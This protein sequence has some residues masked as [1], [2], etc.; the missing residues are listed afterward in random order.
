MNRFKVAKLQMNN[1]EY[2]YALKTIALGTSYLLNSNSYDRKKFWL[3][4]EKADFLFDFSGSESIIKAYEQCPPI[5]AIINYQVNCYI[6]GNTIVKNSKGEISTSDRAKRINK[7]K[8][9]PNPLQTEDEFDA[10]GQFYKRLFG[11]N[12]V[13]C[14]DNLPVG[15]DRTYAKQLW[16]IPPNLVDIR[17][18][19]KCFF[20]IDFENE[21]YIEVWLRHGN[22]STKLTKGSYHIFKGNAPNF[23]NFYLPESPIKSLEKPINNIIGAYQSRHTLIAKRGALGMISSDAQ[24]ANGRRPLSIAQKEDLQNDYQQYYGLSNQQWSVLIT[25]EAVKW[26]Q[27]GYPTKDLMLFEEIEEDMQ[28]ICDAF[29]H[30]YPLLANNNTNSLGGNKLNES[31]KLLYQDTIIPLANSDDKQ[32]MEFFGITDLAET[33]VTDY[34]HV[35]ALQE[36]NLKNAQTRKARNEALLIEFKNNLITLNRWL[37]LNKEPI[38]NDEL[39]G[40]Y[41]YQLLQKGFVFGDMPNQIN[42]NTQNANNENV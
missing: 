33:I 2:G 14:G 35:A 28:R 34:S 36:D 22:S 29:G 32:W 31:K 41:Y 37:E 18:T 3:F 15:F 17:Y 26:Q 12:I 30:Q 1:K 5:F 10:Q 24:D 16:N 7:L 39:G 11:Y 20:D 27:M 4:G 6:N 19:T 9:K 21:E 8:S 42:V 40:L 25:G 13:W 23:G 38:R